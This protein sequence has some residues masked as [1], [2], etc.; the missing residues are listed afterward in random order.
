[1]DLY[2]ATISSLGSAAAAIIAWLI[3]DA[4]SKSRIAFVEERLASVKTVIDTVAADSQ[5]RISA[6]EV[7]LARSEQDRYELRRSLDRLDQSKASKEVSDIFSGQLAS[8]RLDMDKRF[9][10][11]ERILEKKFGETQD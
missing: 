10:R 7:S 1:L 3:A 4:K 8:L 11:I 9:D 2:T 6:I 5:G